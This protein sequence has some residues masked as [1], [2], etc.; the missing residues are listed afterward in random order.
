M[1]NHALGGNANTHKH[2][3][4][5]RRN[6]SAAASSKTVT[7]DNYFA[8]DIIFYLGINLRSG[9]KAIRQI[10]QNQSAV[11]SKCS[12]AYRDGVLV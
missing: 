6:A 3:P 4:N 11:V 5:I 8:I 7:K 9:S 1:P 2:A 12:E 10:Q